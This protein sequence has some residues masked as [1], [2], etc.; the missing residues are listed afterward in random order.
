MSYFEEDEKLARE[1]NEQWNGSSNGVSVSSMSSSSSSH[2]SLSSSLVSPASSLTLWSQP[3]HQH[4][5]DVDP[6]PQELREEFD[7]EVMIDSIESNCFPPLLP[8]QKDALIHG[9]LSRISIDP[10]FGFPRNIEDLHFRIASSQF[11]RMAPSALWKVVKV[12]LVVNPVLL[13]RYHSFFKTHAVQEELLLFHGTSNTTISSILSHG[14]KIGGVDVKMATG[15]VHGQGVYL[16]E[17]P[18]FALRYV[19]HS[20]SDAIETFAEQG[21]KCL[22][23][24]K[25]ALTAETKKVQHGPLIEQVVC[26]NKNQ[27]LP[28]YLVYVKQVSSKK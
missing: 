23:F 13:H 17:D 1:L 18:Q 9:H 28:F 10:F 8:F 26:P 2:Y 24:A 11:Y 20:D 6:L 4:I 19:R 27:V 25:C 5:P 21:I 12:D 3:S 22:L 15:A 16:S 7:K 14:F